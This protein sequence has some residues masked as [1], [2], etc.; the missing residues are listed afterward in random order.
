MPHPLV[1]VIIPTYNRAQMLREAL[2]SVR[3][4]TVQDVE[5]VVIDDG[6]SDD[7]AEVVQS[8]GPTVVLLRQTHQ[9]VAAARNLGIQR[10]RASLVA[11]LDSDDLWLPKKLERQLGYLQANPHVGLVYTRMWSY[12]IDDVS[13]RRLEPRS[14]ARSFQELLNG[15][16]SV[17]TSTVV[18][19]RRCLEA[20]GLFN[21]TLPAVEDHELWLRVAQ[22][23]ALGFMDEPL[24]EYRRHGQSTTADLAR[25]HDGYRRCY[26]IILQQYRGS[27]GDARAAERYLAKL[28][29]LCG[30]AAL[31]QGHGRTALRM[32]AGGL[33][34]DLLLG[35]GFVTPQ[36]PLSTRAWLPL[37]PYG[38]LIVSAWS[39]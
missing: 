2:D 12:H 6:S 38:A 10:S 26:E 19:R 17:T 3:R 29:Y 25:L 11:F 1:S 7:T 23:F 33:R 36:T 22:R 28:E 27:L 18:V 35:R 9:G 13:R 37:K 30:T 15:P 4:Q 14:V 20:V 21:P 31:R 5:I 34:R 24:A 16:N 39:S 8:Y 32:I